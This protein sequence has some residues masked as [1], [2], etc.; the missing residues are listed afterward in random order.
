MANSESRVK[1][2]QFLL[3]MSLISYLSGN[4]TKISK[5]RLMEDLK[6]LIKEDIES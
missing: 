6:M 4:Y 2:E 3:C 5:M 1:I